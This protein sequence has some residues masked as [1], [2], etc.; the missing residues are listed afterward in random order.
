MPGLSVEMWRF[1]CAFLSHW[2]SLA[3]GGIVTALVGLWER[4][5]KRTLP[6]AVYV[7]IFVIRFSLAGFFMAWREQF[8]RAERAEAQMASEKAKSEPRLSAIIQSMAIGQMHATN[9]TM[10]TL[11]VTVTNT[12]APSIADYWE[13]YVTVNRVE[14]RALLFKL[15][16]GVVV[17]GKKGVEVYSGEDALYNKSVREPIPTGGRIA[18]VPLCVLK[19]VALE[20]V[21]ESDRR[22]EM[23]VKLSF[24]DAVNHECVASNKATDKDVSPMY[25]PGLK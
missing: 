12:G 24:R 22:G 7:S 25:Y 9:D 5:L 4:L 3:T 1:V 18:G 2:Q 6:T 19:G 16:R 13:F 21:K 20:T 15:N 10:F 11:V 14:H 17:R 8:E 23:S